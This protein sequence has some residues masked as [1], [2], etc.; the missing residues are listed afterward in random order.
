MKMSPKYIPFVLDHVVI[1]PTILST[2]QYLCGPHVFEKED[3]TEMGI[4]AER[5][6]ER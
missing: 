1:C 2:K 4:L 6:T 5:G 3:G